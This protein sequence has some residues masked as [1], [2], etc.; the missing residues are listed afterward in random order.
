[1]SKK[2]GETKGKLNDVD[3]KRDKVKQLSFGD[4]KLLAGMVRGYIPPAVL[5]P[6]FVVIEVIMEVLIPRE[7]G[8]LVDEGIAV[9]NMTAVATHGG[10]MVAYAVIALVSG[11]LSARFA[12][13]ASMGFAKNLRAAMFENIQH[14]SFGNIDKFS[15]GSLVTRMTTDVTFIRNAFATCIRV[16]FR[17]PLMFAMS[18]AIAIDINWRIALIF[19]AAA[20]VLGAGL[21]G[22]GMIA[23]PLFKKMFRRFDRMN[24]VVQENLIGIRVVKAFVKEP[25]ETEK[26]RNA[27][28]EVKK[29]QVAAERLFVYGQPLMQLLMFGCL[30]AVV[31]LG[32]REI[33]LGSTTMTMG[34]LA[35]FITYVN[36][37]LMS[38]LMVAMIL[39][40]LVLSSASAS[41]V[42]EVLKEKPEIDDSAAKTKELPADGSIVFKN[43]GFRYKNSEKDTISNLNLKIASGE[44]VGILGGTGSA[45]STLVQLIP[46][47]YDVTEGV[48]EVGGQNVKEYSVK[49]LREA[50]GMVLQKNVLFS[51]T[52]RDNL[53]WG[54]EEASD[55]ELL[56]ACRTA[57]ADFVES[58]PDGLD[59]DLGQGGVNLSGGQ[60][61]RL[62]I[63][64][65]ILKKP[66]IMILDDS[67]SAVDT[68][69]DADIRAA[70]KKELRGM[71][72]LII[73]QRVSSV[74]DADKILV[75]ENGRIIGEGRHEELYYGCPEYRN[76]C[77]LQNVSAE[78]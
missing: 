16:A 76:V 7:M 67:T 29:T 68:H 65:A 41:R 45:K 49:A 58:F 28:E 42:S 27:A 64:R 12:A 60:K 55:E 77:E 51:G 11:A 26:F 70:L 69:T 35:S 2:T 18:I 21:A 54:S 61:Q 5:A 57:S 32:G 63:A 62:C 30:I 53:K 36:Q 59:T 1:M 52:I 3:R 72:V 10:I 4:I 56:A 17:A 25:H 50:V 13:V 33:I 15:T 40:N 44:T 48:V 19:V 8:A 43:V 34:D 75:M 74:K 20:P 6:L 71:T 47:L 24:T 66:K 9:G 37:I 46:R 22:A 78:A 38:L 73:A 14:F 31:W 39:V 23:F